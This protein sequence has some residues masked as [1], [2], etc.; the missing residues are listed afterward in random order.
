MQKKKGE[1]LEIYLMPEIE[2]T[3]YLL[4]SAIHSQPIWFNHCVTLQSATSSHVGENVSEC[5]CLTDGKLCSRAEFDVASWNVV[6][7][8][9]AGQVKKFPNDL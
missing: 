4:I 3:D 9:C 5:W 8:I 1:E 6:I 7:Q 2:P